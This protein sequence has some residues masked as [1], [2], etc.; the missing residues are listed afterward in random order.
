M[1]FC[2]PSNDSNESNY[3]QIGTLKVMLL[4]NLG[5]R[6]EAIV[7]FANGKLVSGYDEIEGG[8]G[9][10]QHKQAYLK[11]PNNGKLGTIAKFPA[12]NQQTLRMVVYVILPEDNISLKDF[13]VHKGIVAALEG[14][15]QS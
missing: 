5:L 12:V 14:A 1:C 7:I 11:D 6:Y 3:I 9:M 8:L 15:L 2:K 13:Y 4:A 10:A